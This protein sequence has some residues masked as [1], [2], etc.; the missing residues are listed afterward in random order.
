VTSFEIN[1][2]K[3]GCGSNVW[4]LINRYCVP[5]YWRICLL[6]RTGRTFA[7]PRCHDD[8]VPNISSVPAH[9]YHHM[10][11]NSISHHTQNHPLRGHAIFLLNSPQWGSLAAQ[12]STLLLMYR[13]RRSTAPPPAREAPNQVHGRASVT[14]QLGLSHGT[15]RNRLSSRSLAGSG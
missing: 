8:S 1:K 9:L 10:L 3:T 5:R 11:P 6:E 13:I 7:S 12:L 2:L 14:D 4:G 15:K